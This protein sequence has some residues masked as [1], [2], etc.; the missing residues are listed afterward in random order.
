MWCTKEEE[1]DHWRTNRQ[2]ENRESAFTLQEQSNAQAQQTGQP[3]ETNP[4]ADQHQIEP[5]QNTN[6]QST[7]VQ[8]DT[9]I[10]PL[11]DET[12]EVI[13]NEPSNDHFIAQARDWITNYSNIEKPQHR[14]TNIDT[15][16][17]ETN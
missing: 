4:S 5:A 8:R 13:F 16:K 17:K 11:D 7:Q 2:Q 14:N 15:S 1:I 10:P 6:E 12:V 9:T 3:T